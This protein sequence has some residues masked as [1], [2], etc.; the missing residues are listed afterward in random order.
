MAQKSVSI[1]EARRQFSR[2]VSGVS[3]RGSVVTITQH[4]RERAAL[5]GIE[6]Y[7]EIS[8][9]AHAFDRSPQEKQPFTVRGSLELCCS[10]EE[11]EEELISIRSRWTESIRQSAEELAHELRQK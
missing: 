4:G 10:P 11:L 3:R 7:Q 6:E 8:R 2:L 9:K 1:S 5:I